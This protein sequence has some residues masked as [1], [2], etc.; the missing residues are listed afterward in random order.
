MIMFVGPAGAGKSVQGQLL[1]V[2]H[3]LTWLS[4]GKLLRETN[5]PQVY[6]VM[7]RGELVSPAL[8]NRVIFH[9]LDDQPELDN[10]IID[11]YPRSL[12]QAQALSEYSQQRM[13]RECIDFVVVFDVTADE[14]FQRLSLRG[15][16]D[17]TREVIE[18]RLE[19]YKADTLPLV[20]YYAERGAKVVHINGIGSRG[21]VLDRIESAY[22]DYR[23]MRPA[24]AADANH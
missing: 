9:H 19:S 3:Q 8:V 20:N 10:I 14:I 12:E 11:G 24:E 1:A 23:A 2:C 16:L 18:H 21:E 15:R 13:G 6:E 22:N 5:D 7:A 4:A 17:D